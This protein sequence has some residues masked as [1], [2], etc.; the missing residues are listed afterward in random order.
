MR[1]AISSFIIERNS[2]PIA[3]GITQITVQSACPSYTVSGGQ[4]AHTATL[5]SGNQNKNS[6]K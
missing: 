4:Q 3:G 6:E 1:V 5:F 2:R